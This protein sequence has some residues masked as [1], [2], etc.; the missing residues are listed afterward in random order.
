M[1]AYYERVRALREELVPLGWTL[2][3]TKNFC[4]TVAPCGGH[5]VAFISGDAFTGDAEREPQPRYPRGAATAHAV[6]K[7]QL[8]F[9]QDDEEPDDTLPQV[10]F[11]VVHRPPGGSE[12]RVELSL[13]VAIADDGTVT[14]WVERHP[15]QS[16]D[17][18]TPPPPQRYDE[19]EQVVE[20][21]VSRKR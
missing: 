14:G 20:V 8:S 16:I 5:A 11:L 18:T 1:T 13:P 7:A 3:N 2:D 17:I 15:L 6:N 21:Q 10:W 9:F 19:V 12:V 4:T